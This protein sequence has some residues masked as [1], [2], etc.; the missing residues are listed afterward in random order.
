MKL[1]LSSLEKALF[2]LEQALSEYNQR[3][4]DFIRDACIQRFKYNY[5]LSWKL[6]RRYLAMIAVANINMA[7]LS[8]SDLIR[9]GSKRNLL[10]SDW[11]VWKNYRVARNN[12][13]HAYS[14]KKAEEIFAVIPDFFK[15]AQ[16]LLKQLQQR[17]AF[18]GG[19]INNVK[20]SK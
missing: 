6:L 11:L 3:P 10:L 7:A 4:D 9:V 17:V 2:S 1:D 13:I 14:S 5:E 15:D 20:S 12:T 19:V 8:F 16:F 18:I